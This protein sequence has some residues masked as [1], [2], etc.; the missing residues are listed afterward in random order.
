[1]QMNMLITQNSGFV[2][3][4]KQSN[5]FCLIHE[6]SEVI[7][8]LIHLTT[9]Q[10]F[11]FFSVVFVGQFDLYSSAW[12]YRTVQ[13]YRSEGALGQTFF[14]EQR[15]QCWSLGVV[16]FGWLDFIY[17][18]CKLGRQISIYYQYE[19]L[20]ISWSHFILLTSLT[21]NTKKIEVPMS[22][23]CQKGLLKPALITFSILYTM[24]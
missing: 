6:K 22:T 20:Q 3:S 17:P 11:I 2:D 18:L 10:N 13:L 15:K 1:M 9:L 5:L 23:G 7:R 19:R 8:F 24:R 14:S 16:L 21:I 12:L 4:E